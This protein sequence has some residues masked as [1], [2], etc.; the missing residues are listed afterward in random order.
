M[1]IPKKIRQAVYAKCDGHCAYCG[2]E[3]HIKDM[4]VDHV[5][6]RMTNTP[7]YW[8]DER[9]T[10]SI[11]N[12]LPSCRMC[13]FRK[14]RLSINEFREEL[15]KQADRVLETFQGR[16]SVFYGLIKRVNKPIVF[17]YERYPELKET[18]KDREQ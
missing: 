9:G 16:M 10:E 1:T 18:I 8:N 14:E 11:D 13:N 17:Y 7:G 4:Q 12:F 5:I 15:A 2:R 3:L 6:P